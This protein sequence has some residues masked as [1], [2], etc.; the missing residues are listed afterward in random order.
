M[1]LASMVLLLIVFFHPIASLADSSGDGFFAIKHSNFNWDDNVFVLAGNEIVFN[2]N[3]KSGMAI[4]L[5][6]PMEPGLN[7]GGEFQYQEW[8]VISDGGAQYNSAGRYANIYLLTLHARYKINE[9]G[10]VRPYLGLGAGFA[11]FS[12]HSETDV[13]LEGTTHQINAA[14]DFMI[15]DGTGL[16]LGMMRSNIAVE[17][18]HFNKI[19]TYLT[20]YQ[21]S[22][23]FHF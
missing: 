4:E 13:T 11:R 18:R 14:V 5:S 10:K 22:I 16:S 17:D 23:N 6:V 3:D 19:D 21:A 20:I 8:T 15:T 2:K 12:L 1:R 9:T 7:L